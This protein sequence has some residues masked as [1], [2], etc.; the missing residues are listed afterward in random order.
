MN[1]SLREFCRQNDWNPGYGH[2]LKTAGRLVMVKEGDKE[3]VDVEA[4]LRRIAE[5]KD[6]AKGHMAEVNAGQRALHRGTAPPPSTSWG[7]TGGSTNS[8]YHQA[9]TAREVYEAKNAQLDFEQRAGRLV[10]IEQVRS[11]VQAKAAALREAIRQVPARLA[12]LLAPETDQN[13]VQQMLQDE[14]DRVLLEQAS[15]HGL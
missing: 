14:L 2:K 13:R 10:N 4:S 12:P 1:V 9:K 6:L 3:L 15:M 8:T 5:S 7:S 11:R